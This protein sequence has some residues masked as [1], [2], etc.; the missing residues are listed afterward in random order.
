MSI[1][2]AWRAKFHGDE[3][4]ASGF[5]LLIQHEDSINLDS[6]AQ[7]NE[8][9]RGEITPSLNL[10]ALSRLPNTMIN[11]VKTSHLFLPVCCKIRQRPAVGIF[12]LGFSVQIIVLSTI[13]VHAYTCISM[14][15]RMYVC[16]N[17]HMHACIWKNVCM[18]VC[19]LA[20]MNVLLY[21][22]MCV[23]M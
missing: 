13:G 14:L 21:V 23:C 8:N 12:R 15:K 4:K 16:V 6:C 9:H 1:R 19:M 5:Y 10:D 3:W 18:Y 7:N 11:I 22:Y 2:V 17:V 20:C